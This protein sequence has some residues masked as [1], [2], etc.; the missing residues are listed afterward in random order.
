MTKRSVSFALNNRQFAMLEEIVRLLDTS[1]S[2]WLQEKIQEDYRVNGTATI[3][4]A[5]AAPMKARRWGPNNDRCNPNLFCVVCTPLWR[6]ED[7]KPGQKVGF[8]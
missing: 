2:K 3:M 6:L 4:G 8:K 7:Y 5:H 1:R